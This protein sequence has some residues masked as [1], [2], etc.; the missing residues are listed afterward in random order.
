MDFSLLRT[1]YT[2]SYKTK[3]GPFTLRVSESSITSLSLLLHCNS[4]S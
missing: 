2:H 1:R 4:T 3:W